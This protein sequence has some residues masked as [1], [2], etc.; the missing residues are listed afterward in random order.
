MESLKYFTFYLFNG[1]R[2]VFLG[3][4]AQDAYVNNQNFTDGKEAIMLIDE[5]ITDSYIFDNGSWVKKEQFKFIVQNGEILTPIKPKILDISSS[6]LY[7]YDNKDQLLLQKRWGNFAFGW[8]QY[9]ELVYGEYNAGSYGDYDNDIKEDCHYMA[10]GSQYFFPNK[11]EEAISCFYERLKSDKPHISSI[12]DSIIDINKE[13]SLHAIHVNMSKSQKLWMLGSVLKRVEKIPG[14]E[15]CVL[16]G[17]IS[18]TLSEDN[19]K[20]VLFLD[21]IDFYADD[22]LIKDNGQRNIL[23][24]EYIKTHFGFDFTVEESDSFGPLSVS[25]KTSKGKKVYG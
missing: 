9:I 1:Q 24:E 8:T 23:A 3:S 18:R 19:K 16:N 11:E 22:L 5:G 13:Q 4:S 7:E 15:E 17:F 10:M 25:I 2:K 21:Y 14:I 12:S 20:L 6:V